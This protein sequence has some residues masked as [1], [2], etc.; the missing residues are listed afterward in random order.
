VN[1]K[2]ILLILL[3]LAI[4]SPVILAQGK[5]KSK[6]EPSPALNEAIIRNDSLIAVECKLPLIDS[7][8]DRPTFSLDGKMMVFG[9]RRPPMAGETW[10]TQRQ[11]G[12]YGSWDG[13]IYYRLLTDTG[14]TIPINAGPLINNGNDQNNPTIHPRGDIL[15]YVGGGAQVAEASVI[16][17]TIFKRDTIFGPKGKVKKV[18]TS[19]TIEKKIG[20]PKAVTGQINS[21]YANR[22]FSILQFQSKVNQQANTFT[23]EELELFQRAPDAKAVY[24]KEKLVKALRDNGAAKFYSSFSRCE[25]AVTPDGRYVIFAENF[26]KT[27]EYGMSGE[28]DD[29][30]WIAEINESGGWDSV[31]A[32]NGKINSSGAE[33]YPFMAADGTTLY[34]SS[35]RLCKTCPPGTSGGDD[36]YVTRLEHG[37]FTEPQ[38]LPPP[39]NS[40]YGDYGFS[41][42]PDG[43]TA[44]F[45]SNRSGKSKFYQVRLRPQ[46]SS[47]APR[48]IIILA[49]KVTDK[50]TGKPVKA[51]VFVDELTEGKN[52]FSVF[53][54][55]ASGTYILSM[56]RGH[57]FGLQVV[58]NGYLPRS[59]RYNTPVT[60]SFD[61]KQL[62]LELMPIE[63]GSITEF[64]NVYFD[65]N[66]SE[67]LP[68][69]K[70]ELDRVYEFLKK[71]KNATVEIGGHTD[72]VGTN[73][74]NEKLSEERAKSVMQYVTGKGIAARRMTAKGYG[75]SKPIAKGSD[76]TSRAKNRRVEMMITSNVQ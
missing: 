54:D 17:D 58:A 43:E 22:S 9:S 46:D 73:E 60:G 57:R 5:K 13:E 11:G 30:L 8:D 28:G 23:Q 7:A 15:Y 37:G 6:K 1:Y 53:T 12:I 33:T 68:E 50:V 4:F 70:L 41:I 2:S 59:E 55:P 61:R 16:E 31:R 71:N 38:P 34:F 52:S 75:K 3:T 62:D 18:T 76:D 19:S 48:P 10:R 20:R 26:G 36:I 27:G 21:I 63:V 24:Q 42:S 64:K 72:D 65:F 29:D 66:K 69:S 67:L 51:E 32:P 74:Y 40:P 35:D 56:L 25:N 47:I 49:G 14:W 44:Y 45:V 39:F